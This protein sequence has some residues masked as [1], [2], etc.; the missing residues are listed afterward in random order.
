MNFHTDLST[1][2]YRTLV[3]AVS[4]AVTACG[5]GGENDAPFTGA[6]NATGLP[7]TAASSNG[8]AAQVETR[9]T[10]SPNDPAAEAG[11]AQTATLLPFT[12]VAGDAGSTADEPESLATFQAIKPA[13]KSEQ[14][15]L[16]TQSVATSSQIVVQA[17]AALA[18]NTG[19]QIEVRVDGNLVGTTEVRSTTYSDLTFQ[20][21]STT[22]AGII[23]VVY[24]NDGT[25]SGEDRN[26]WVKSIAVNGTTYSSKDAAMSYDVGIGAAAFDG[27]NTLPGQEGLFW[28]GSLRLRLTASAIASL[29]TG[30]GYF[31]DQTAG[32]D[33]NVGSEAAPFKTLRRLQTVRLL[34]GQGFFLKCG[35][36]WRES[37]AL[38]NIQLIDGV[39]VAGYGSCSTTSKAVITGADN[40]SG[41]WSLAGGVWSRSLPAGTPII[42]RLTINGT[43][44]RAARWPNQTDPNT[45]YS[46]IHASAGASNRVAKAEASALQ[47][48]QGRDIV[49]AVLHVRTSAW[50][51]ESRNVAAFDGSTGALTL[52]AATQYPVDPGEGYVLEGKRWMLDAAGEF[53]HDVAT[54]TLYAIAPDAPTQ[55]NMN[56]AEV[57]GSVRDTPLMLTSSSGVRVADLA[58]R[59]GRK[60]GMLLR[61]M[62]AAT[63]ERIES[64]GNGR[65]GV[66]L[67][68]DASKSGPI[69]RSSTFSNNWVLGIDALYA[70]SAQI[71]ANNV[72]AT[73]TVAANGW[74]QAAIAVGPGASVIDNTVD[75]SA[76]H[77]IR[78]SGSNGSIVRG[79]TITNYCKRLSDCGGIYTWNGAKTTASQASIVESNQVLAAKANTDGAAGFGIEVVV[80]VFLDDYATG[81]TVRNNLIYGTPLGIEVHNGW[82]NTIEYNRV[83]L[84]TKA[85]LVAAMDQN[86]KDWMVGNIF[87]GNQIVPMKTG[88]AMF[89]AMP[90]FQESHPIWFFNNLS[91]ST[92]ISAGSNVFTGNQV[93]R[94]DGSL[95]GAHAWIRSNTEDTKMNSATWARFNTADA[96][97]ATPLTFA[98]YTLVLGPE[99]VRGGSFDAGIG[100]WTTW[101]GASTTPGSVQASSGGAG[102]T[103]NCMRLLPGTNTD[104]LASPPF[105][106]TAN[107]P[108]VFSYV[109][110]LDQAATL[111]FPYIGRDAT[112]YDSMATGAF[113][114][115][116]KLSGVADEVIRYEGFFTAKASDPARVNLQS[117]TVGVPVFFDNVSVRE[118]QGF[119][120]ST[121]ADWSALAYAPKSGTRTVSCSSL[122]WGNNCAIV[123]VDG[124]PVTLPTTLAAGT[125]QLYLRAD[126]P[127]RR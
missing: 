49:G 59:M 26:L 110:R 104:Y 108:H 25:M 53:F 122:G 99:L 6:T 32:S 40:F 100:A 23:D 61:D 93:V 86:D 3:L 89:P 83:W 124:T 63:V 45:A 117:K 125:Q 34:T 57:E 30:P 81:V 80:G 8:L 107:T 33:G 101:F 20:V 109:A 115:S 1:P 92:S 118:L 13:F 27:L 56:A 43:S 21:A 4:I 19:A 66:S 55:S 68:Q 62:P 9:N 105:S 82:S 42:T 106:M 60:D 85:A 69:I 112:P 77:G 74:S 73:G 7:A 65:A 31:V 44:L 48:L 2:A 91:G 95:D 75:G 84:P 11:I 127:W 22:G 94:L 50:M 76:Y 120:F 87:R 35:Q 15:M 38:T 116:S 90:T 41:S 36:V 39:A 88:S 96:P 10:N 5:G 54:N 71:T 51:I 72:N 16:A 18:G 37:M 58:T 47:S 24:V 79:N 119:S 64:T 28:N 121:A 12:T 123:T 52:D 67:I 114:S 126:S 98:M 14:V 70:G 113:S 102:C 97:T 46:R 29:P 17:R 111:R 78:F 103:G